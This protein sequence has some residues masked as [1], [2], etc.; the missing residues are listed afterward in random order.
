MHV[1]AGCHPGCIQR[2]LLREPRRY[3]AGRLSSLKREDYADCSVLSIDDEV[4]EV[5]AGH[6]W[7]HGGFPDFLMPFTRQMSSYF[8]NSSGSWL[9][10]PRALRSGASRQWRWEAQMPEAHLAVGLHFNAFEGVG[11]GAGTRIWIFG[12]RAGVPES[13][14]TV[15]EVMISPLKRPAIA[16]R[17]PARFKRMLQCAMGSPGTVLPTRTSPRTQV[18]T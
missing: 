5:Y 2:K 6:D 9:V 13:V 11:V 18:A 7:T 4:I 3:C 1:A 8:A 17:S 12:R 16:G 14:R 10:S 15:E